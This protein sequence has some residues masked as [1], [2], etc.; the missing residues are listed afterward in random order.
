VP[1]T[2][3]ALWTLDFAALMPT[4]T[5]RQLGTRPCQCQEKRTW[6]AVG[7]RVGATEREQEKRD[8]PGPGGGAG[9][10][11]EGKHLLIVRHARALP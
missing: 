10:E 11:G 2:P 3:F 5:V 6:P 7:V 9:G 8:S 1:N 4:C